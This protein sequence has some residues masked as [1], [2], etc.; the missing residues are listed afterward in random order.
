M[1]TLMININDEQQERVLL[2]FLNSLKYNYTTEVQPNE[3]SDA[4][5]EEILKREIDFNSGKI[6]SEPWEE[7]RKRFLK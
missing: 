7:V 2:A 6:K 5:K 4:Q 1:T 3:I